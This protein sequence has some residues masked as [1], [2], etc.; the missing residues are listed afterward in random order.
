MALVALAQL[1]GGMLLGHRRAPPSF[2]QCLNSS[3]RGWRIGVIGRNCFT[4]HLQSSRCCC[5]FVNDEL[6]HSSNDTYWRVELD[7][8]S[9]MKSA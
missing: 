8:E 5:S 7:F 9:C 4:L 1:A 6:Q 3:V 2:L